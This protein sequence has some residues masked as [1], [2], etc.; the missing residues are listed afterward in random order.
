M[1]KYKMRPAYRII[2]FFVAMMFL[3]SSCGN[4][5]LDESEPLNESETYEEPSDAVVESTGEFIIPYSSADSINPFDAATINNRQLSNLLY[6]T[7]VKLDTEYTVNP[8]LAESWSRAGDRIIVTLR[9]GVMFT[10]GAIMTADDVVS[11]FNRAKNSSNYSVR[12]ETISSASAANERTVEFIVSGSDAYAENLLTFP[13]IKSGTDIGTGRYTASMTENGLVLEANENWWGGNINIKQIKTVDVQSNNS[14]IQAVSDKRISFLYQDFS[15]G[16]YRVLGTGMMPVQLN[17]IVYLGINSSNRLLSNVNIRTAL[18]YGIDTGAI[19]SDEFKGY[20]LAAST[21]FNPAWKTL[22][23]SVTSE[24]IYS[25]DKAIDM[26]S[27]QG[28]TALDGEGTRSNGSS[29]LVFTLVVNGDNTF[30][31]NTAKLIAEQ[32]S[33]IGVKVNVTECSWEE[34]T[35]ALASGAYD[36]YIGEVKIKDNMDLSPLLLQGGAASY[37]ISFPNDASDAY[38]QF[39]TGTISLSEFVTVFKAEMPFVPLC[40]RM[41]AAAYLRELSGTINSTDIDIYYNIQEW[42]MNQQ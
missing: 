23:Q 29:S 31:K 15:D 27:T 8:N 36:L 40:Y 20:A 5:V 21:P 33:L 41:G 10:D 18:A 32:L 37:G 4:D 6:D 39:R 13:V 12:L 17:N 7:L 34:Y 28:F 16:N 3:F 26:L 22:E 2:S 24:E 30:K 11:S 42:S 35:A 38:Q 9:D 19:A 25:T 14:A 1:K